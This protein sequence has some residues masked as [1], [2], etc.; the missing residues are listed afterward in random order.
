MSNPETTE[1]TETTETLDYCAILKLSPCKIKEIPLE[2]R[3][4]YICMYVLD[5]THGNLELIPIDSR[6]PSVCLY[7]L[8]VNP[9]CSIYLLHKDLLSKDFIAAYCAENPEYLRFGDCF[10]SELSDW[11][12]SC[13]LPPQS[14]LRQMEVLSNFMSRSCQYKWISFTMCLTKSSNSR[15]MQGCN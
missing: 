13:G 10:N 15:N 2:D 4:F 12:S 7:A 3:T 11:S 14:R 6:T 8:K 9:K 5:L 1:T